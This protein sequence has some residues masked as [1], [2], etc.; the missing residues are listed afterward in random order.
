MP[1]YPGPGLGGHCIPLDP[2]YLSWKA[3][4]YDFSTRFIELAGQI[5]DA[6]PEHVVEQAM[7]LLNSHGKPMRGTKVLLLGLAYKKDIDDIRE[8]PALKIARMLQQRGAEVSYHDPHI[9]SAMLGEKRTFSVPL[10]CE[11]LRSADLV[12]IT[13]D[14]SGVDY[15]R[16]VREAKLI[17]D[18]RNATHG[19]DEAHVFRLG[20]GR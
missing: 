1:F 20:A 10:D 2:F 18:T 14:H 17:F 15:G 16:V 13:T 4:A 6:M 12:I 3:K 7:E 5:N 8:S 19:Y 11:G 9:P